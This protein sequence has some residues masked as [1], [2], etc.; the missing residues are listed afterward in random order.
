[1][2]TL[3]RDQTFQRILITKPQVF[4]FFVLEYAEVVFQK[5]LLAT[6]IA[7][8]VLHWEYPQQVVPISFIMK[9]LA[10]TI[11]QMVKGQARFFSTVSTILHQI[12]IMRLFMVLTKALFQF[13][14]KALFMALSKTL[15]QACF[16]VEQLYQASFTV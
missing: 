11:F 9:S 13:L 5:S 7:Q 10:S 16:Q 8:C 4:T 1:M 14:F 2:I 12:Q 3:C 6:L 15:S